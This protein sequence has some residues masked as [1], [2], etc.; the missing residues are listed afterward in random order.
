MFEGMLVAL[1]GMTMVFGLGHVARR[2]RRRRCGGYRARRRGR[3]G[4]ARAA[5]EVLKRRLDVDE[6]QELVVDHALRDAHD[7]LRE[8]TDALRD[9]RDDLADAFAGPEVDQ[10]ALDALFQRHDEDLARAR[11]QVVSAMKQVH[12]VLDDEQRERAAQ[13]LRSARPGWR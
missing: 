7:S 6:E 12:A 1:V 4:W 13:A 9:G 2:R 10:A 8:W 3:G 5:G 11:R